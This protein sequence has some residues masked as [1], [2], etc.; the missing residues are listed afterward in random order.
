MKMKIAFLL[1]CVTAVFLASPAGS[2]ADSISIVTLNTTPLTQ[3]PADA[4]GPFTLAFQLVEG[5]QSNNNI[6]TLSNFTFGTGGSAGSGCPASLAPCEIGGATGDI[7]SSVTLATSSPFNAFLE[8][9]TPGAGLSF[10]L[11]LTTNVDTGGT[12]DAFAFSI[13]DSDGFS[14]PTQDPSGADTL[15]TTNIDGVTL[16]IQTFATDS[17]RNT[18]GG[19]G[20]SIMMGAATVQPVSSGPT[21]VPEPVSLVLLGSGLVGAIVTRRRR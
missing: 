9:F 1:G 16:Q 4:A 7:S 5:S 13:L 2:Y 17:S 19:A 14:I 12:P 20:P 3:L 10:T 18:N 6:A 21:P 11:D 8:L 15:L